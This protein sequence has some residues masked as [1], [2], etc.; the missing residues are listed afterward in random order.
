MNQHCASEVAG[1]IRQYAHSPPDT[2]YSIE[3]DIIDR[4]LEGFKSAADDRPC[5]GAFLVRR[6]DGLARWLLVIDWRDKREYYVVVLS[7][8][9]SL[10]LAEL[11]EVVESGK[12]RTLHWDYR[13]SRRKD[14][15]N[16]ER[17]R[18]FERY[19]GDTHAAVSIPQEVD[20]VADFI[21]ELFDLAECRAKADELAP[22]TP[23]IGARF[24]EGK[25]RERLHRERERNSE[26][27]RRAK[28]EALL[29]YGRLRCQCCNFDF[30]D[31]YGSI[32]EG[33]VEAHHTKP[34][35]DIHEDGEE[36]KIEDIALVCSNCH[37]MLH[38]KRPWLGM[39]EL[40]NLI[41]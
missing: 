25:F 34:V 9:K 21:S 11:R 10:I 26:V 41:T 6:A 12:E 5:E 37:S 4:P 33:Y 30:K 18:Y 17:K 23:E 24:N 35:S 28:A 7:D 22:D 14:D 36:T 29:K 2:S 15:R 13:P 16:E 20:A 3:R 19:F 38:R 40:K 39:T 8:N 27:T 32:G 31:V 1:I